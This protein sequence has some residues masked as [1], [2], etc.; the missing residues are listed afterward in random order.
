MNEE[1]IGQTLRRMALFD[2]VVNV[3]HIGRVRNAWSRCSAVTYRNCGANKDG[4]N[5]SYNRNG[6]NLMSRM[7]LGTHAYQQHSDG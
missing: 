1:F 2:N 7:T 5:E 6:I 4:K 3:L